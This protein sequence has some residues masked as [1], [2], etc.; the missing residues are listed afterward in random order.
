MTDL[1]THLQKW[2]FEILEETAQP[3]EVVNTT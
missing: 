2:A 1:S 3:I